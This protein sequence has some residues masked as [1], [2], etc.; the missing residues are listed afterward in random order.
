[1]KC[2]QESEKKRLILE[3]QF[4]DISDLAII[5]ELK[6]RVKKQAIKLSIYP[7]QDHI[8]MEGKDIDKSGGACLPIEIKKKNHE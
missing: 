5:E 4:Q 6:E 2:Y 1:M 3:K 7:H 8:F